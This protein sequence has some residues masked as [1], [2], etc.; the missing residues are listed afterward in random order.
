MTTEFQ[1]MDESIANLIQQLGE[2]DDPEKRPRVLAK[3]TE[4]EH[5]ALAVALAFN[6]WAKIDVLDVFVSSYLLLSRAR[7]G[8]A[9]KQLTKIGIASMGP[10]SG[11]KVGFLDRIRSWAK[12]SD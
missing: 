4:R 9:A 7:G 2:P 11:E 12:G 10:P 3:I 8:E 1:T 5:G 6:Q